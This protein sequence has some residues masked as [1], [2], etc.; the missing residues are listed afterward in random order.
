[1]GTNTVQ[2]AINANANYAVLESI[3]NRSLKMQLSA[4]LG[5]DVGRVK[6][7]IASRYC[8]NQHDS[9]TEAACKTCLSIITA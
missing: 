3:I 8:N 7:I 2:H 1:M 6:Q 9:L 4:N 5:D